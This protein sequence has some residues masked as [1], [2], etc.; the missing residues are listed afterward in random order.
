MGFDMDLV[1]SIKIVNLDEVDWTILGA[2]LNQALDDAWKCL[3]G[4]HGFQRGQR[5]GISMVTMKG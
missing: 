3:S 1:E 5:N 4:L 2:F